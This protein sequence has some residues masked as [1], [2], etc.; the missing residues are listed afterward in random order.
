MFIDIALGYMLFEQPGKR[1]YNSIGANLM[2]WKTNRLSPNAHLMQKQKYTH[3]VPMITLHTYQHT[4]MR[5]RMRHCPSGLLHG[6]QH[7]PP[8][9]FHGPHHLCHQTTMILKKTNNFRMPMM[10][11]MKLF[12]GKEEVLTL[13]QTEKCPGQ[14]PVL[15]HQMT[16]II[17]PADP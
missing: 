6:A 17:V 5:R 10:L 11:L 2:I 3:L 7:H 16:A 8:Y 14:I 13:P 1:Y 15:H 12:E 9:H 4:R